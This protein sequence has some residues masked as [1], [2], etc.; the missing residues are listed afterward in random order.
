M[1]KILSLVLAVMMLLGVTGIASA[2]EKTTVEIYYPVVVSGSVA[3]LLEELMAEF[4]A[5]NPDIDI[6][7]VFAGSYGDVVNKMTNALQ[8]GTAPQLVIVEND[9]LYTMLA[10]DAA[11][12]LDDYIAKEGGEEF[13]ADYYDIYMQTCRNEGSVYAMPFQRSVLTMYYNRDMFAEAGLPDRAPATW[14]EMLEWGAKLTKK[15]ENGNATCWGVRIGTSGWACQSM[16]ITASSNGTLFFAD[17]GKSVNVVTDAVKNA[18]QYYLDLGAAG[19]S[20]PGIVSEGANANDFIEEAAGMV[21]IS[22]GN[23]ANIHN[24]VDFNYGVGLLPSY[25]GS[26]PGAS[27]GSGGNLF[28]VKSP[29]TT[30]EQ[31]DAAWRLMKFLSSP[32]VQGRWAVSTGYI[33]ACKTALETEA[34][35]SYFEDVPMAKVC[36]EQLEVGTYKQMTTYESAQ[37]AG[38]VTTAIQSV[39][40]GEKTIDAA[41]NEFQM[42]AD[43]LLMDFQ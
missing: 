7:P 3:Q 4:E 28:M 35:K 14:Q 42:T 32:E 24:S 36:Y 8:A 1:K 40:T 26:F 6:L 31:Y 19:A 30:Q 25:D 11:Y 17:D 33:A 21:Y 5:Q 2:E 13:L 20:P 9:K 16:M 10:Q 41:L 15:D 23:L 27:I 34:M 43:M 18:F 12:C 39:V 38:L 37:V 22:S 29:N